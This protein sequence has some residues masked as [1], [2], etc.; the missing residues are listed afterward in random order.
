MPP[1]FEFAAYFGPYEAPPLPMPSATKF[2]DTQRG[3]AVSTSISMLKKWCSVCF[4]NSRIEDQKSLIDRLF[5]Q[6]RWIQVI[7]I[8]KHLPRNISKTF[9]EKFPHKNYTQFKIRYLNTSSYR[10]GIW[11]STIISFLQVCRKA[12][13]QDRFR[14]LLSLM[15]S[16]I[17]HVKKCCTILVVV[18]I[19]LCPEQMH[20]DVLKFGKLIKLTQY[21]QRIIKN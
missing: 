17:S 12:L 5:D 2:S 3:S 11:Y 14:F 16:L 1:L 9:R 8:E 19:M 7:E 4:L 6:Y 21:I 15:I 20:V 10:R 13:I 18:S